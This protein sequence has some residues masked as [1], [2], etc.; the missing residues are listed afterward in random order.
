MAGIIRQL[1]KGNV[2][3]GTIDSN[4]GPAA[5][6]EKM[7]FGELQEDSYVAVPAV[8]MLLMVTEYIRV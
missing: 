3:T 4:A 1:I 8:A 6:P 2:F 7:I 5:G